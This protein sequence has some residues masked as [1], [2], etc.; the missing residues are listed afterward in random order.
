M[1]SFVLGPGD[2]RYPALLAAMPMP[3]DLWVR[4]TLVPDDALAVAIVGTRRASAYGV[5]VA[6]RLAF[7]LAARGITVVSGLARGI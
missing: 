1:Q 5:A 3:P 4:G 6:E 7:D 2:A